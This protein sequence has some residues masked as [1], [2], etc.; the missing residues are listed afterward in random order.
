MRAAKAL[1][2]GRS[3]G[4]RRASCVGEPSQPG[5]PAA[6]NARVTSILPV[7]TLKTLT[8]AVIAVAAELVC[9]GLFAFAAE[10]VGEIDSLEHASHAVRA[11]GAV[12][13]F[14]LFLLA[15]GAPILVVLHLGQRWLRMNL[16]G[17][18]FISAVVNGFALNYF[19]WVTA[20]ANGSIW[21]IDFP[22]AGPDMR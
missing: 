9:L 10:G 15:I 4:T 19:L 21:N 3:P 8:V 5:N 20:L 18:V 7:T 13:T 11:S 2:Y 22:G 16:L 1:A 14:G 6:A 17:S 12:A